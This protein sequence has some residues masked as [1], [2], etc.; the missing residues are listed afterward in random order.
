MANWW[1]FEDF[2]WGCKSF[3]K[4][5]WEKTLVKNCVRHANDKA[6]R[7]S[8]RLELRPMPRGAWS[9]H[10]RASQ[11]PLKGLMGEDF[12]RSLKGSFK[13]GRTNL[14]VKA[15]RE[16]E[17]LLKTRDRSENKRKKYVKGA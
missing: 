3:S 1:S 7:G 9:R 2:A 8:T 12:K 13:A 5:S 6:P 10:F 14:T 15:G 11:V 4:E 16:R 17:F